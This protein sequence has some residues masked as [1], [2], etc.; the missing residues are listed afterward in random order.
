MGFLLLDRLGG[1]T[2]EDNLGMGGFGILGAV[3]GVVGKEV[4]G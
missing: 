1:V 2:R 4:V 3:W